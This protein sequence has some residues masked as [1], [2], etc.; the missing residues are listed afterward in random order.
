[1]LI[2]PFIENAVWHGLR[3]KEGIGQLDVTINEKADRLSIIIKDNG[4]GRKRSTESKTQN[5]K[6]YKST[7]LQN[8]NK[9]LELIN[10]LYDKKYEIKVNDLNPESEDTGTLVE[11]TIP[12]AK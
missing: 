9:R 1:M 12:L 11:I 2:Q 10:E 8:V 5:Q 3:Y 4:I 7:G 6:K